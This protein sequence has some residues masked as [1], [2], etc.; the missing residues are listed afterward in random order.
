MATI[1]GFD[2]QESLN[3]LAGTT[4]FDAQGAANKWAGVKGYDLVGALNQ[5][6]G[7]KNFDL[8]G[9]CTIL[10]HATAAYASLPKGYDAQAALTILVHG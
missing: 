7:K 1:K 9:I 5:K 4:G 3:A 10:L 2:L 6:A 8:N